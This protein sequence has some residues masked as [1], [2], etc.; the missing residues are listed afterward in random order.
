MEDVDEVMKWEAQYLGHGEG[1]VA[2]GQLGLL[3]REICKTVGRFS[4]SRSSLVERTGVQTV[5]PW[6]RL[7]EKSYPW[8]I[9]QGCAADGTDSST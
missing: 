8:A 4:S 1:G 5:A 7:R 6:L 3:P 9:E 2:L